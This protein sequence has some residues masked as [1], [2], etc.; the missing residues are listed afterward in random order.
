MTGSLMIALVRTYCWV[1]QWKNIEKSV[2][3]LSSLSSVIDH[4]TSIRF[5]SERRA[6]GVLGLF[7][8]V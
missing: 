5:T 8:V 2:N 4:A 3:K 6:A 7:R 1:Y